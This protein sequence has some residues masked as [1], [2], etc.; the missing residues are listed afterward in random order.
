[1]L[2]ALRAANGA[3]TL[4]GWIAAA[5]AGVILVLLVVWLVG[6]PFREAATA[7]KARAGETFGQAR[8]EAGRDAAVITDKAG[9]GAAS[10]EQISRENADAIRDACPGP[11]CN[12]TALRR[13]CN[14]PA[15]R[16][17]AE[18]VQLLGRPQPSG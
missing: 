4:A 12:D 10:D 17:N 6:S 9:K 1:M 18:C 5:I 14:R 15:Y 8:T 2:P 16:N 13:V 3:L 7:A 11:R